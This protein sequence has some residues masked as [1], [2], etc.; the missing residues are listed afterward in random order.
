MLIVVLPCGAYHARDF[1]TIQG[2]IINSDVS[3]RATQ[4]IRLFKRP[5]LQVRCSHRVD[6]GAVAGNG[7]PIAAAV[8]RCHIGLGQRSTPHGD[9][10]DEP[11][12][13]ALC[14]APVFLGSKA[15]TVCA[16]R[17]RVCNRRRSSIRAVEIHRHVFAAARIVCHHHVRPLTVDKCG[18]VRID[19]ATLLVLAEP[20]H[21]DPLTGRVSIEVPPVVPGFS[22]GE[23]TAP[24]R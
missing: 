12:K 19:I 6:H 8:E 7:T 16:L 1:V 13:K 3:E 14:V 9:F 21:S 23:N 2:N 24:F 18:C 10:V 4:E 15:N 22:L 11:M 5:E 20:T 17:H